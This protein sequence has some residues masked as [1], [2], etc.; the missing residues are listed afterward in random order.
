M[1]GTSSDEGDRTESDFLESGS[2]RDRSQGMNMTTKLKIVGACVVVAL[3]AAFVVSSMSGSRTE[4]GSSEAVMVGTSDTT[5][6]SNRVE[7]GAAVDQESSTIETVGAQQSPSTDGASSS[8]SAANARGESAFPVAAVASGR[9]YVINCPNGTRPAVDHQASAA[10]MS[11]LCGLVAATPTPTPTPTTGGTH[12]VNCPDGR[13]LTLDHQ[14]GLEE[15]RSLCEVTAPAPYT[16]P[17]TIAVP[18]ITGVSWTLN[19][20]PVGGF[21]PGTCVSGAL[22]WTARYDNGATYSGSLTLVPHV[23]QTYRYTPN[24]AWNGVVAVDWAGCDGLLGYG[25]D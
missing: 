8:A 25:V 16:P 17:T 12:T 10:E 11:Q 18:R 20:A 4:R 1:A 19:G 3:G 24:P 21:V 5:A 6:E 2:P 22:G 7:S 13:R 14:A 23:A 15:I 9:D